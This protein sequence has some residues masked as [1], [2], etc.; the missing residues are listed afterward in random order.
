MTAMQR[1]LAAI[2]S[3]NVTKTN[4]IGIRKAVNHVER[5]RRGWSGN[6]SNATA[7]EVRAVL[8]ALEARKPIVRG[9]LHASGVRLITDKRYRKRLEPVADKVAALQGFSLVGYQEIDRCHFVPVYMAWG[10]AGTFRFYSIPWQTAH[11]AGLEG[12]PHILESGE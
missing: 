1:H 5:L 8:D 7:D 2:E 10:N 6:R 12:G 9:E 3:G 4:V 11:Y